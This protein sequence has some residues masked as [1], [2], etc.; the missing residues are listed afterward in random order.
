MAVSYA[1][2][3]RKEIGNTGENSSVDDRWPEFG[4]G[5][6][7]FEHGR[8]AVSE[9]KTWSQTQIKRLLRSEV[10]HRRGS[11]SK[12]GRGSRGKKGVKEKGLTRS[13]LVDRGH[14]GKIVLQGSGY[15]LEPRFGFP[16]FSSTGRERPERFTS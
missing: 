11:E 1:A 3:G 6:V 13:L 2:V 16:H 12:G 8:S 5:C 10:I 4:S 14:V 7:L 15:R 9:A